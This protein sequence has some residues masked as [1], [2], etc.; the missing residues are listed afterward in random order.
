MSNEAACPQK[1]PT[2]TLNSW[3]NN[4][5]EQGTEGAYAQVPDKN[6]QITRG[7]TQQ[8]QDSV[9]QE[10]LAIR[11]RKKFSNA[12]QAQPMQHVA[13]SSCTPVWDIAKILKHTISPACTEMPNVLLLK[14]GHIYRK[15]Q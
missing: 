9:I 14:E 8:H 5:I 3:N 15:A 2:S 1:E 12:Q 11:A 7:K 4:E 13:I 10:N 6:D